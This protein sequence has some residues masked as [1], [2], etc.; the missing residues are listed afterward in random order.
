M[1]YV[2]EHYGSALVTIAILITLAALIVGMLASDGV[3]AQQFSNAITT[4]FT[5]MNAVTGI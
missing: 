5:K 3:I 4:F 2:V 1:K